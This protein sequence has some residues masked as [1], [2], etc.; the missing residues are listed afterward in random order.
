MGSNHSEVKAG[1]PIKK[2]LTSDGFV[3]GAF[4]VLMG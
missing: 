1:T 2:R 4:F 3:T